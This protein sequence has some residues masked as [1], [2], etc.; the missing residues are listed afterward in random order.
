MRFSSFSSHEKKRGREE[1]RDYAVS[2]DVGWLVKRHPNWSTIRSIGIAEETRTEKGKTSI[3]RR[4]FVSSLAPDAE[5]FAATVRGHW[6][7][8]NTLHY[9]L[10]VDYGEDACRIR[11][12]NGAEN[13]ALIR[14][15][16]MTMVR[17]DKKPKRSIASKIKQM[18]WS[19]HYLEEMLF[20]PDSPN[21]V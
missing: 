17:Q 2:W 6:G 9:V 12:K 16:A 19:E 21:P 11:T 5:R 20:G 18:A 8:E 15:I 7:I 1:D 3:E 4:Y 13:M 10:D 14:K